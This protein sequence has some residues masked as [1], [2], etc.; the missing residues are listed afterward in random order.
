M[1]ERKIPMSTRKLRKSQSGFTMIETVAAIAVLAVGV[2]SLAA[3]LGDSI[4]YMQSSQW[5]YIAQQE[6][7]KAIESIFTARDMGQATWASICNIG[8][9]PSCIFNPAATQ[10]CAPGPDGILGTADDNCAVID[11]ILQPGADGTFTAP[12]LQPLTTF[13]RTITIAPVPGV[14]NLN[15]ITVTINYRA[16]KFVRRY[17]L[18]TNISN[19]S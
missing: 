18:T 12:T 15:S 9:G 8:T 4:A 19:F 10:L 14:A 13:T 6:A 16:G 5:D 7:S 1:S 2:L 11:S 3:M 17:T